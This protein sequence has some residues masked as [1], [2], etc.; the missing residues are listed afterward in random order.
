MLFIVHAID[1]KTW[2]NNGPYLVLAD[3]QEEAEDTLRKKLNEPNAK[4]KITDSTNEP[5]VISKIL[6]HRFPRE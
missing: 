2:V 6:Y 4:Y 5:S 3:N 1:T